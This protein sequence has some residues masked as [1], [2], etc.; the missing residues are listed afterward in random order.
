M[1]TRELKFLQVNHLRGPNIWTYRPVIEAWVDIGEFEQL[2]SNLLPGFTDRLVKLLPGLAQHRC[3]VGEVGGFLQRL[4]EGTWLAH[5]LE[6]VTI[7]LQNL[8][9]SQVGFG[10]ARQT[11]EG[12]GIYKV[13][14]RTRDERVGRAAIAAARDLVMAAV[15]GRDF[16]RDATVAALHE[17]VDRHCLGPSTACIVDAAVERSIPWIRLNEGNLVQLGYGAAQRRIWTAE[18]DSTSAIAEGICGDKDLTKSLLASCG[19]PVPGG[20]I[21]E[22][23]EDAWDAAQDI[24]LPVVVK[25]V[26][27]N[28]GRGVSLELE[29]R[30]EIE[31]AF[32]LA[33]SEGSEVIVEG[34]IPGVEHRLLVVGGKVVAAAKGETASVVGDGESTVL[35]LIDAQL[36]T[37]P[38]RGLTEVFPLNRIVVSEDPAVVLEL[39]RQGLQPDSVPAAGKQVLIQ[40]NGNVATDCTDQVCAEVGAIAGLAA[41]IVGLDV[42][43]IDLVATDIGRPLHEQ[44]GAIVEVNAGPGLLMHLKP[45]SGE[46]QPVGKAIVG[47]LFPANTSGRI[48]VVGVAGHCGGSQI[49]RLVA[50]IVHLAGRHVGLACGDGLFLDRRRV[51]SASAVGFV[52]GNSLLMNRQVETVVIESSAESILRDGLPYDRCQVGVVTGVRGAAALG[53]FHI[54]TDE[55]VYGVLRTQI[56]VVLPGGTGVLN[57]ADPRAAEMVRLCDGAVT[58]YDIDG[59]R[60]TIVEHRATGGHAV[61]SRDGRIVLATG[62]REAVLRK[63]AA[64]SNPGSRLKPENVL[65]AVA[66]TWALDIAPDLIAAGIETFEDSQAALAAG[67]ATA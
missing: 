56:D 46:P 38:R 15:E 13:A 20:R 9:G 63:L 58:L 25:P 11:A 57:A 59:R 14:V 35:D 23:P 52:A 4:H 27:G 41:R 7:E 30:E 24:G 51:S 16:D 29:T 3:G 36:N 48:P 64:L 12:S 2:P 53:D 21:V 28:H 34:F 55:Q 40:R 31:A 33:A 42:A 1:K 50:W 43:G 47:H 67:T 19:V 61:F 8:A 37:D 60:S 62:E 32:E 6:H 44:A 10:K 17:L 26:D 54:S 18:T 22:S 65:A 45:A 66:A 49:S 39:Q 5:V